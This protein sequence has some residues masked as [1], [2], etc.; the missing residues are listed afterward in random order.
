VEVKGAGLA[1]DAEIALF[2][3]ENL[4]SLQALP[5]CTSIPR[6]LKMHRKMTVSVFA[7]SGVDH[8]RSHDS[9]VNIRLDC[10]ILLMHT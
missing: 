3:T 9:I 6:D 2:V 7:S 8:R 10:K 5:M 1:L 4:R